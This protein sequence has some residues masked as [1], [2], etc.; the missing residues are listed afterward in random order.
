MSPSTIEAAESTILA[1]VIATDAP[2]IPSAVALELLK[3]GFPEAD[4]QR[5]AVLASRARQG[6]LTAEEQVETESY[7]RVS[8]FLGLVK[9]KA[10][11]SLQ[12]GSGPVA[13]GSPSS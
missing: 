2:T 3:W 4:K 5:M 10:R 11:R 9:S 6:I 12:N 1:R 8:S 7:E 13:D